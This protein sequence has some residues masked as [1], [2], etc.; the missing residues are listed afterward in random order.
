MSNL[1]AEH[2]IKCIIEKDKYKQTQLYIKELELE[3]DSVYNIINQALYNIL[4][5]NNQPPASKLYALRFLK[6][7]FMS[8]QFHLIDGLH[9]NI[10][11]Q[12]IKAC[13]FDK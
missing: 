13:Q 6:D 2:L 4:V 3:N 1:S 10:M 7:V 9:E 8:A 11:K 12:I 5:N